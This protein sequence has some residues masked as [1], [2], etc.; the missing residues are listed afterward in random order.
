[1]ISNTSDDEVRRLHRMGV[2]ATMS[3]C[4]AGGDS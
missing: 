4:T 2:T 1:V 3:W